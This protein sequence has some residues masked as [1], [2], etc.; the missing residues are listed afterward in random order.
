MTMKK[1]INIPLFI[2]HMGCPNQCVFCDQ[3]TISGTCSFHREKARDEIETVLSTMPADTPCEI[4]F[5]GG[6]FTGIDRELMTDL[7]DLAQ[8]YVASGRVDGIRM[9]TRPDYIDPE[10]L[11]ILSQYTISAVELGIQSMDEMVLQLCKRGHTAS[12]TRAACTRLTKAGIPWVGQMMIGLPGATLETELAC[13]REICQMG[14]VACRIYPTIV[15][16]HTE[17]AAWTTSGTYTPLT[18]EEAVERSA[19]VLQVF[20]K[21]GVDC[22]RIGLCDSESLHDPASCLAGPVHPAMGELVRSRLYRN[23]LQ[24]AVQEAA[25]EQAH[26]LLVQVPVGEVSAVVGQKRENVRWIEENYP[27]RLRKFQQDPAQMRYTVRCQGAFSTK[28]STDTTMSK[29]H[30]DAA[31]KQGKEA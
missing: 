10:I 5:F 24:A 22:L 29:E 6:S 30:R 15:L 17:L 8:T 1:H 14:A 31:N 13:A 2:P 28:R 20:V 18:V 9:S 12:Q 19:A 26:D 25:T 21:A 27:V 11:S 7:L 3:H 16:Q 4:A 23:A